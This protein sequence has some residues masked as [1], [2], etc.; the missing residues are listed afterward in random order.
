MPRPNVLFISTHDINPEIGAY[1][2]VWPGAEQATTPHL[3]RLAEQGVVYDNA[4]AV[5]PVCAPSRSSI[6]TG[7]F[8]TAIGTMHMRTKAV[9][10]PEVVL[11]PQLLRRAGYH[12]TNNVFTDFQLTV[13]PTV[14]DACTPTAHWRDRPEADTPFFAAFHGLITHESQIYLDDEAFAAATPH[15]TAAERHDPD[16]VQIPPYHPDT[17]VF[18]RS[19]ARYLDLITE[20]DHWVGDLLQQLEDDGLAENTVVVFWSD[21][22]AGFPRGKRWVTERGLRE[23]LIVRWPAGLAGGQHRRELVHLMDLAPTLLQACGVP[24]PAHM[25]GRPLWDEAGTFLDPNPLV[26]AGRDRMDEQEDTSRTV[27][28]ARY[29]YVRHLH[30]DRSPMQHCDYPDHLDTWRDLR[31]L[32]FE[33]ADQVGAGEVRDRLTPLQ[34]SIVAAS[35]PAEELYDVLA[36]PHEEHDLAADPA[37][38][39]VLERLRAA[40][41]EWTDRHGD[42]GL[43]PE[44]DLLQQWRPGGKPLS[45]DEPRVEERDGSLHATC[46]TPGATVAW[47]DDPP[48]P[49]P[50]RPRFA[51]V[52]G[53]PA[54]DGRRWRLLT[55][56][57][58][59]VEHPQVWFRAFRLGYEPSLDVAVP[60]R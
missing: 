6:M 59:V 30:P 57:L 11:F 45:T 37:H 49:V 39:P 31:R 28:D 25:H 44:E 7:C 27:R 42:L 8:P 38:R 14:F 36:D 21:H 3:D 33:E 41:D 50:D 48:G 55:D 10:P 13:P 60:V 46:R 15:V 35:K 18:R 9:P 12:T 1:A 23:P 24:V 58:P 52:V 51:Q 29:R 53:I 54:D 43:L 4:F 56:P 5:A 16:A 17:E 20:M 47:T 34:R 2:G 26:F 22:G 19:W 40:L 32:A